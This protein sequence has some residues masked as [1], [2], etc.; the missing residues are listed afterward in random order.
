[1]QPVTYEM[2]DPDT[3]TLRRASWIYVKIVWMKM[4]LFYY[5]QKMVIRQKLVRLFGRSRI[6]TLETRPMKYS[7]FI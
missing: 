6:M 5:F 4:Q 3:G 7:L 2:I 1:M